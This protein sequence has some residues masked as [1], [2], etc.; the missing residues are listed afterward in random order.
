M[1]G[2]HLAARG[3]RPRPERRGQSLA[4]DARSGTSPAMGL[5]LGWRRSRRTWAAHRRAPRGCTCSAS[6]RAAT[7]GTTRRGRDLRN[8][9]RTAIRSPWREVTACG[10]SCLTRTRGQGG[11]PRGRAGPAWLDRRGIPARFIAAD[12]NATLTRRGASACA[13]RRLC[14]SDLELG[15]LVRRRAGGVVAYILLT[16]VVLL[17]RTMSA[18]SVS[19][20]AALCAGGRAPV[21]GLLMGTSSSST[22]NHRDRLHPSV[23]LLSLTVPARSS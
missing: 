18:G 9:H 23:S 7:S 16:V 13:R 1:I 15:G 6:R 4:V 21:G 22:R 8:T 5:L 17:G 3:R 11:L 10:A 19:S 2:P 20:L 12:G 14:A